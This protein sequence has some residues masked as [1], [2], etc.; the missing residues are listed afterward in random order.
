MIAIYI[1]IVN[2]SY[3]YV[4]YTY[5]T[6]VAMQCIGISFNACSIGSQIS[7]SIL[8]INAYIAKWLYVCFHFNG[9]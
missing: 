1:H 8:V 7:A 2:P 6:T 5:S 3:V 4:L 9:L